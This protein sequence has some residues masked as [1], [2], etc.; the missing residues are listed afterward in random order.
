MGSGAPGPLH[1]KGHPT[2]GKLQEGDRITGA[3]KK[4]PAS[5]SDNLDPVPGAQGRRNRVEQDI[6]GG[7]RG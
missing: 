4:Y 3:K 7:G 5:G 1:V 2:L 6:F